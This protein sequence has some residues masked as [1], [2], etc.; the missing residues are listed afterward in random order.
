MRLEELQ[1]LDIKLWLDEEEGV[2]F[3]GPADILTDE[4]LGSI[5]QHRRELITELV[6]RKI[7]EYPSEF[8]RVDGKPYIG[9]ES[10][11]LIDRYM[12]L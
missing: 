8:K 10:K 5:K 11:K 1:Q 9:P 2:L 6:Q 12:A 4:M 7:H 3:D